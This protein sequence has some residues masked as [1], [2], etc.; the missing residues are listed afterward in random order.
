M[1]PG[2]FDYFEAAY[3]QEFNGT[4]NNKRLNAIMKEL[5]EEGEVMLAAEQNGLNPGHWQNPNPF[6]DCSDEAW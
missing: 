2:E 1:T 3:E 4:P 6:T 5:S